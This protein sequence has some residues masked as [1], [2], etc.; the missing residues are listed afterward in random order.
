MTELRTATVLALAV[1]AG[2]GGRTTASEP[3]PKPEE[4]PPYQRL[5]QGDDAKRAAA[6]EKRIE[7]FD[8]AGKFAEAIAAAEELLALRRRVQGADHWEAVSLQWSIVGMRKVAA[9]P[10]DKLANWL[11]VVRNVYAAERLESKNAHAQAL[12]AMR[13]WL[14]LSR[15]TLG[16]GHPDTAMALARVADNL[17]EQGKPAEAQPLYRQA[18]ERYGKA[19]GEQHPHTALCLN[20]LANNLQHLGKYREAEPLYREARAVFLRA[21]GEE[22]PF[23]MTTLN[24]LGANLYARGRYADAEPIFRDLIALR[25]RVLGADD[26]DTLMAVGNLASTL[27]KLGR[28]MEAEPLNRQALAGYRKLG[29]QQPETARAYNNLAECLVAQGRD[30]EAAPLYR[31]ALAIRRK[32]RGEDHPETAQ[33]Y[34]SVAHSLQTQGNYAAADP[35]FRRALAIDQQRFGEKHHQTARGYN[36][37]ADNLDRQGYHAEAEALYRK[38]LAIWQE[39]QGEHDDTA[40]ALENLAHHLS[41]H[42]Q[43]AEAE[44]LARQAVALRTRLHGEQHPATAASCMTL[45]FVLYLRGQHGEAEPLYRRALAVSLARLGEYHTQTASS[46]NSL[47]I[48]LE[49][50]GRHA[51]AEALYRQAL[52][53]YRRML[54]DYHPD[55]AT[56]HR[57][58]AHNLHAQGKYEEAVAVWQ[59]AVRSSE[60]ARLRVHGAGLERSLLEPFTPPGAAL[61]AILAR[62]GRAEEAWQALEEH[63]GRGLL[64]ELSERRPR[65]LQPAEGKRQD[66][67]NRQLEQVRGQLLPLVRKPGPTAA[68]RERLDQ[69]LTRRTALEA[70]LADL[71]VTLARREVASLEAVQAHLPADAALLAWVDLRSRPHAA[72]PNGEHWA[73]VLRRRGPPGW[74]KLPGSSPQQTWTAADDRLPNQVTQALSRR[75]TDD[76]TSAANLLRRLSAQRLA[77]VEP[78]LAA[79]DGLPAVQRLV[80]CSAGRLAGVPLEALAD[81]RTVSYVP[82]GTVLVRLH[83][84]R[85]EGEPRRREEP[86]SIL[87][88]GD[89]VFTLPSGGG[90]AYPPLPGT[91]R[92]VEAVAPLFARAEKLLGSDASEQRLE[93]L[94]REDRLKDYRYLHF[95]THGLIDQQVPRR[96]ALILAQ[97]QLPDRLQRAQTGQKVQTGQLTVADILEGWQLNAELVTLSACETALGRAGGGD[98]FVGFSQALLSVGARSCVLSL[99]QVDDAAT[100]LLMARFYKN[101]LGKASEGP[102]PPCAKAEALREAKE[103]LRT[104]TGEQVAEEVARLPQVERGVERSRAGGAGPEARPYAHPYYWSAFILI[105]DPD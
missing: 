14:D 15:E 63:L 73:C 31:Q 84:R 95:A 65:L 56:S 51:E 48:L 7:Q 28:P 85:S 18:L 6:L 68:E 33:S 8:E 60:A 59:S 55:T 79:R 92:E 24:N 102:R 27:D 74:V 57:N 44:A 4:K 72:D 58:L 69:L 105:G 25:T 66:E 43:P 103:W 82:S 38:A 30:A 100:S 50:Q 87:A 39:V 81:R 76:G 10:A 80:V 91:R 70:E 9:L 64:D 99:W 86:R 16:D 78:L 35:L 93:Q 97:D 20:S 90:P 96:S 2:L 11:T 19:L 61:A 94:T 88:L 41:S 75:P 32:V 23:A 37:L 62:L 36:N 42:D 83:Q 54:G 17:D 46:R 49:A 98:G 104:L 89:P 29:E 45:A 1:L 3:K 52:A 67:I 13:R 40:V 77:P 12:P 21:L 5:L 71:A 22:H 26:P 53:C 34:S 47:A 101:L